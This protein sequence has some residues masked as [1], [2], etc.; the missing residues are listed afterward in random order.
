MTR[1]WRYHT[2]GNYHCH[3]HSIVSE[4]CARAEY[5]IIRVT[6]AMNG[7]GT[8]LYFLLYSTCFFEMKVSAIAR[9][10]AQRVRVGIP[11]AIIFS[12]L[13][14]KKTMT[15]TILNIICF[16]D[17]LHDFQNNIGRAA[18]TAAHARIIHI[19]YP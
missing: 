5:R 12:F 14:E 11:N 9:N 17:T 4:S 6:R 13:I 16:C 15:M 10:N 8:V 3:I 18:T 7:T 19:L 1:A 2:T